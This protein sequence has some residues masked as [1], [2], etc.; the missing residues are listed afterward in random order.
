MFEVP[1]EVED[2]VGYYFISL[3]QCSIGQLTPLKV[4]NPQLKGQKSLSL[5]VCQLGNYSAGQFLSCLLYT[6]DAADE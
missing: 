4:A 5:Q 3:F 2:G 6:S 1:I